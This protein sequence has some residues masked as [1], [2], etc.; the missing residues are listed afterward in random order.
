[1]GQWKTYKTS[2]YLAEEKE[3]NAFASAVAVFCYHPNEYLP[4]GWKKDL[5]FLD[6]QKCRRSSTCQCRRSCSLPY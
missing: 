5:D 4:E 6:T 2:A 1:M 3:I